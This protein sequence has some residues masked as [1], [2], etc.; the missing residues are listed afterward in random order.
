MKLATRTSVDANRSAADPP[1]ATPRVPEP[2]PPKRDAVDALRDAL[3]T[4]PGGRRLHDRLA[5]SA[6]LLLCRH[7]LGGT[8]PWSRYI[9]AIPKLAGFTIPSKDAA[10]LFHHIVVFD[11][12]GV[13]HL[14]LDS[15]DV[16][17]DIG[18]HIGSFATLCHELGSRRIVAYEASPR[19]FP[20]LQRNFR[21]LRGVETIQA[22]VCRSD[23]ADGDTAL[24]SGLGNAKDTVLFGGR[25]FDFPTQRFRA[26]NDDDADRCSLLGI[27][28]ILARFP[29]V[30]L[31]KLDCEGSEFPILLTSR[32][33]DR[34]ELIVG[35][36]HETTT[37]H[38]SRLAAYARLEGI[39]RYGFEFLADRLAAQHFRVAA[40]SVT[41]HSG[42]F[43]A[44]RT[45]SASA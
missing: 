27:D 31:L 40:Y 44:W 42:L 39:E 23:A 35:E 25:T 14:C 30:R 2:G 37:A 41:L 36:Y 10:D 8:Y 33:L 15:D 21:R 1:H 18:A 12:Y 9:R 20:V 22:A 45:E 29:R 19:L 6:L 4:I 13:S 26:G 24:I 17:V 5:C 32:L 7:A 38:Y 16:V 11:E 43:T 34:V 28:R 3:V